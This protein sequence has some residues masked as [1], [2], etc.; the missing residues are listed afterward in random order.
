[1]IDT[2]FYF[3][4]TKKEY[5]SALKEP[6]I[7]S[8]TI[9]FVEDEREIYLDG[10]GY[11]KTST[12]GLLTDAEYNAWKDQIQ[13]TLNDINSDINDVNSNL[14]AYKQDIEGRISQI[15]QQLKNFQD[16]LNADIEQSVKDVIEESENLTVGS[17]FN[18][19]TSEWGNTAG[20]VKENSTTWSTLNQKVDSIGATVNNVTKNFDENGNLKSTDVLTALIEAGITNSTSYADLQNRW[21]VANENQ[22]VIKWMCSGFKS[23]ASSDTTFAQV[24]AG[25]QSDAQKALGMIGTIVTEDE[26]GHYV[27]KGDFITQVQTEVSTDLSGFMTRAEYDAD[28]KL[29]TNLAS[30]YS[31]VLQHDSDGN[32]LY[33]EEGNPLYFSSASVSTQATQTQALLNGVVTKDSSDAGFSFTANADKALAALFALHGNAESTLIQ[34]VKQ[35][36]AI[37]ALTSLVTNEDGTVNSANVITKATLDGAMASL[38]A[39]DP[40]ATDAKSAIVSAIS[41][42]KSAV[43]IIADEI[44][45][46]GNT[47]ADSLSS[48]KATIADLTVNDA[49]INNATINSA[50]ITGSIM[51]HKTVSSNYITNQGNGI[52]GA[53]TYEYSYTESEDEDGEPT[54]VT[55]LLGDTLIITGK[56]CTEFNIQFLPA[57]LFK[58]AKIKII[59]ATSDSSDSRKHER[60][61]I[62]LNVVHPEGVEEKVED[63]FNEA[64]NHFSV[65]DFFTTTSTTIHIDYKSTLSFDIYDSIELMSAPNPLYPNYY[66][67]MVID[68]NKSSYLEER[69]AALE[70]N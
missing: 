28:G 58:G 12:A 19:A 36:T 42:D 26:N 46:D 47:I 51:Y 49:T 54:V 55:K 40:N 63:S 56:R 21:A 50:N 37:A 15:S 20:V 44:K 38:I 9:T 41:G 7:S 14:S 52:G 6:G 30:I 67:W 1:M 34:D 69:L 33:D 61:I 66:T 31:A 65:V 29:K 62:T 17:W 10:K 35:D 70:S 23:Q 16:S 53:T 45:L 24:F 60:S 48:A 4:K 68:Q 43:Q 18:K 22:E 57:S 39:G 5:D 59:N 64:M 32:V 8:K 27:V 25:A 3:V 13:N 2:I 11:G